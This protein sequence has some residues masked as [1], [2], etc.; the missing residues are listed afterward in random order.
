MCGRRVITLELGSNTHVVGGQVATFRQVT[1][2]TLQ[3]IAMDVKSSD[4]F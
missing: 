2:V 3:Y 1:I 4:V